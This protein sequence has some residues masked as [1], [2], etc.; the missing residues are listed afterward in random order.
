MIELIKEDLIGILKKKRFI[1]L[2]ALLF[3]A[4]IGNAVYIKIDYL[5]DVSYIINMRFF[6]KFFFDTLMGIILIISV[7]HLKY[8]KFCL[9]QIEEKGLKRYANIVSK[10]L[11][12]SILL[13]CAYTLMCLLILF[14]GAVMGADFSS[15]EV[16]TIV[17]MM[18]WGCMGAIGL[19]ALALFFL[20]LFAFPVFPAILYA[21]VTISAPIVL[22]LTCYEDFY[23]LIG[24]ATPKYLAEVNFTKA[25]FGVSTLPFLLAWIIETGIMILL[26]IVVFRLKKIKKKEAPGD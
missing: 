16:E 15:Y 14:L 26:S 10:F 25:A 18:F 11:S 5:N 21:A 22:A 24:L 8:T 23:P 1:V 20:T 7:Y 17:L 4:A 3:L 2:T 19:Y 13:I 9:T 6:L 12:G